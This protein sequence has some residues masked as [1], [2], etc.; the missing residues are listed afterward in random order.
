VSSFEQTN[1]D[2]SANFGIPFET[3]FHQAEAARF[4]KMRGGQQNVEALA[5]KE[6]AT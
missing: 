4:E 3:K 2:G 1:R 5:A 6:G